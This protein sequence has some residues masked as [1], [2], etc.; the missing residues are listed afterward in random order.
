VLVLFC[1]HR[2]IS[3]ANHSHVVTSANKVMRVFCAL[4]GRRLYAILG[5][6]KLGGVVSYE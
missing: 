2:S 1:V 6:D 5:P 4:C 3:L